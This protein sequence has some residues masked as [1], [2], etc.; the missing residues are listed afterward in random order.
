VEVS[1]ATEY[2]PSP[3]GTETSARIPAQR[4]E[5]ARNAVPSGTPPAEPI[6]WVW[7]FWSVLV[8]TVL[9]MWFFF[10]W[11]VL[12]HDIFDAAGESLGSAFALLVIVSIVGSIRRN[13]RD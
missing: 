9:V 7:K 10:A 5:L 12:G 11:L 2:D 4:R 8:G 6:P 3:T 13:H 1:V